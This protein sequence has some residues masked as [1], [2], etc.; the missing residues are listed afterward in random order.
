[1]SGSGQEAVRGD[2]GHSR[3]GARC[4]ACAGE[5][6]VDAKVCPWCGFSAGK[7]AEWFPGSPPP[8][9]PVLDAASMWGGDEVMLIEKTAAKLMS[10]FPQFRWYVCTLA[11]P[12]DTA[13]TT[14][15][16][17]MMNASPLSVGETEYERGWSVLLLLDAE[18]GNATAVPGYSAEAWLGDEDLE[19]ALGAMGKSWRAGRSA[20]GVV[21][22]FKRCQDRLELTWRR[23]V[24]KSRG[25][26]NRR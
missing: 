1:M 13:L 9:M 26:R 11:L 5:L 22:F 19:F 2:A 15:G 24:S 16:Y 12:R 21:R 7:T 3:S 18:S 6:R 20:E 14:F 17:W 23:R 8:M 25:R 10:K 4:P